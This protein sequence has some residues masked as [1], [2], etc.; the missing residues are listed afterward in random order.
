M[1]LNLFNSNISLNNNTITLFEP[2]M[3]G[4]NHRS[5]IVDI[6]KLLKQNNKILGFYTISYT[7]KQFTSRYSASIEIIYGLIADGTQS[8]LIMLKS[9]VMNKYKLIRRFYPITFVENI[10]T[11]SI[12]KFSESENNLQQL[13]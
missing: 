6:N 11:R 10:S 12:D 1:D 9:A 13:Y 3:T 4:Y 2:D 8:T 5:Y 7:P